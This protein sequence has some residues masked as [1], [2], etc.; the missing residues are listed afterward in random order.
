[1]NQETRQCQN[2]EQKFVI[3]PED[4]Q[5]YEKM[6]VPAPTF[7]PECR[8]QRRLLFRNDHTLYRRKSD[9]SDEV[10]FSMYSKD[11]PVKVWPREVWLSDA[12][13]A[14]KYGRDYDFSR[15]FFEQLK[16][17]EN[18]VPVPS[19]STVNVVNSDYCNNLTGAKNSYLVFGGSNMENCLYGNRLASAKDCVSC[20][21]V[22]KGELCFD[23]VNLDQC[24][25]VF[26]SVD[27]EN[28]NDVYFS[29]NLTGCSYCFGCANLRSQKYYIFNKKYSKE[30]Y[31]QKIKSFKLNS[32][33]NYTELMK[34]A[35]KLWLDYPNKYMH[36][37][38]NNAVSGDYVSDSKNVFSSY[39]LRG[40]ED[41]KFCCYT[42]RAPIKDCYDYSYFGN[43]VELLYEC[44]IC[45][46][47]AHN[48]KFTTESYNGVSNLQYCMS[49]QSSSSN[50]FGC[51]GLLNK[52]YCIL[53]KQYTKEEYEELVPK[54]IQHMNDMPYVDKKGIVYKYGEFFPTD[55]SP[56]SYN[57]TMAHECFPLTKEK[58]Q[59]LGYN[60][61]KPE[62]KNYKINI[63]ANQL[64]DSVEESDVSILN[65]IIG[66]QHQGK[67]S[68][69]CTTAF[70]IIPQE[71][72]FYKKL[73]LPLPRLCPNCRHY[74]RLAKRNPLRLWHRQCM[75]DKS[76]HQH[77]G[78]CEVEFETSYSPDRPE[79]VYCE[80]CYQQE[81]A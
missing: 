65:Q 58:A 60:W 50:L 75:C 69:Q 12:L 30:E 7:C 4:F 20:S 32:F 16:E 51:V 76:N 6:K 13:D 45:G 29:K 49:C 61:S 59:D 28:C 1:M 42:D 23:S 10:I 25:N 22:N 5:F 79:I 57:E 39:S 9:Y 37:S 35:D 18:D 72:E 73:N 71:L 33:A 74:E 34:Q 77:E 27:C 67:C 54:I 78:K 8:L 52:Q 62:E 14:M 17:L 64:P 26:S 70:K 55:F 46:L 19:M 3:E 24:Y 56:F 15:S 48:C 47:Q 53:N 36:G 44:S 41:C 40:E 43:N 68:D 2:C 11:S 21:F 31:N 81:T 80:K 63:E 38:H 66:C